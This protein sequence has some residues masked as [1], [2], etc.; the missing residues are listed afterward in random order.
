M[1]ASLPA[2]LSRALVS[3]YPPRWQKRY[4]EEMLDVLDQHRASARTVLS[5]A[6]GAV[7]AHLDPSYRLERPMI[8]IKSKAARAALVAAAACTAL[9]VGV[10]SLFTY[11]NVQLLIGALVWHPGYADG[12]SVLVFTPDQRLLA[13]LV[14]SE[15]DT[16]VV[17]LSSV[18]R[19]GLRQLSSFEGGITVAISP[20]GRLVGTSAYGGIAVLWNV[21]QPSH[22]ARVAVLKAGSSNALWGEAF[23]P[24]SK[25]LAIAY[26]GSA[27]L[28]D[29]A[30]PDQPQLLDV[31]DASVGP[32]MPRDIAFSP[33]GRFLVLASGNGQ[34][35][36]WN[37]TRPARAAPV[38]TITGQGGYFQALAFAPHGD[39][40]AGV[41]TPGTVQV[42]RL[43]D[44]GHP[45]L[46]A[47]RPRLA[48]RAMYPGGVRAPAGLASSCPGCTVPSYAL[49]FAPGGRAL[50]VV[51]DYI[52]PDNS[53]RDTAFTWPVTASGSLAGGTS[54]TRD[55]WDG[56]P[57]VAPDGR[58][59]V[60]GSAFGRTTVGL[61][62]LP[63]TAR[64]P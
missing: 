36:I 58:T 40:L 19:T 51:L 7:T 35:T 34:A 30:R 50:T 10:Y 6:G 27:A 62:E 17:T 22:P 42:Y 23:S 41:T 5:L 44:Q 12:G 52:F 20:D 45:T 2:R 14:G 38:A 43:D 56:Q 57:A 4:R 9:I 60:D 16:A 59:I 61:W 26:G 1:R 48:A 15:P 37:V 32:V 53:S 55:T 24:D 28:W 49:G 18:G 8:H 33:D 13:T 21:A 3:C 11:T 39:L 64:Q 46:T 54:A 31:L 29:V 63:A 25:L 47:S